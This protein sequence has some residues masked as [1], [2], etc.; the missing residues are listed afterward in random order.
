MKQ[1]GFTLLEMMV[2]TLIM[3]IAVVGLMAGIS[4]S[5]RNAS[6]VTERDR[7]VLLARSKMDELLLDPRLP[8]GGV[9]EGSFDPALIGGLQ[10]G[11]R[12]RLSPFDK[13][14]VPVPG[15]QELDRLEVEIWWMS[16]ERRHS[17]A[18]QAY[19]PYVL[20]PQ[21]IGTPQL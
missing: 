3:G 2:A 19:R 9:V 12:A 13:P 14:P 5:M 1:R 18:V 17:F 11:W 4:S 6:R 7:A 10:G 15:M 16:G 8:R 20:R 21:D